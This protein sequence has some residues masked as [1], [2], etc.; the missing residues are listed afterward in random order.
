M[1]FPWVLRRYDRKIIT[2][3]AWTNAIVGILHR[4]FITGFRHDFFGL[5]QGRRFDFCL[6]P[7]GSTKGE[8]LRNK[9]SSQLADS[10]DFLC[11]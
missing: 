11:Q 1:T 7:I 5:W 3:R 9:K 4:P 10:I 8:A 6:R 2:S